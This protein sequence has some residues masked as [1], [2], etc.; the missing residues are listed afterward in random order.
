MPTPA[1]PD[2]IR[3]ADVSGYVAAH[4]LCVGE[5]RLFGTESLYGDWNGAV[6]LLAKDV[7]RS[8]A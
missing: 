2:W 1:L 8:P 5:S 6:L 3:D 4:Q 7:W